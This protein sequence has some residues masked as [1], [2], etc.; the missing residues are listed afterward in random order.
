MDGPVL[1]M[2]RFAQIACALSLSTAAAAQTPPP[3]KPTPDVQTLIN[4]AFAAQ[5]KGDFAEAMKIAQQAIALARD[6]K[7]RCGEGVALRRLGAAQGYLGHTDEGLATTQQA[8]AIAVEIGDDLDQ[9]L[10]LN[11]LA[12]TNNDLGNHEKALIYLNQALPLARASGSLNTEGMVLGNIGASAIDSNPEQS[13]TSYQQG[14]T[15]FGKLGSLPG[16]VISYR[17]L[18]VAHTHLGQPA[19]AVEAYRS[20]IAL[21][22]AIGNKRD[23]SND[24]NAIADIYQAIGKPREA[25]AYELQALDLSRAIG[26]KDG[27][28]MALIGIGIIFARM[29]E[30]DSAIDYFKQGETLDHATGRRLSEAN[31]IADQGAIYRMKGDFATAQRL[32]EESLVMAKELGDKKNLNQTEIMLG[33]TFNDEGKPQQALNCL[34]SALLYFRST[35][36]HRDE[37]GTLNE[38]GR[39]YRLENRASEAEASYLQALPIARTDGFRELEAVLLRNLARVEEKLGRP[40]DASS[41]FRSA[42]AIREGIRGGFGSLT[43]AKQSYLAVNRNV[44]TD[45]LN[46][47]LRQGDASTA[48]AQAQKMKARS[49]LDLL[50]S[51]QV[52]I[53]S[54]LTPDE[55]AKEQELRDEA[56][57]LNVAMV[58]QGV[59]NAVGS[60]KRYEALRDKLKAVEAKL[61]ALTNALYAAHPDLAE[62]R[63]ATTA[64]IPDLAKRLPSDTALLDYVVASDKDVRFFV[65]T[66]KGPKANLK[67]YWAPGAYK[68]RS[69]EASALHAACSNPNK[70]YLQLSKSLYNALIQPAM[71]QLRGKKRLVIC[72]DGALWDV[73]FAALTDR[74]GASLASKFEI[75]YAYSATG[76]EASLARA[77]RHL[78]SIERSMLVV[79]NPDFGSAARFGAL[80]EIPGQRPIEPASRPIEPASRP[81][82]PGSRPIEPASRLSHLATRALDT[83]SLGATRGTAI[84]ALPGTQAEA[85]ALKKLFPDATVLTG[86]QAQE[87]TFKSEAG[88]YRYLHLATHGFVNDGSPLLSSVILANPKRGSH[89][90]GFLTAREIYGMH[91]NADMTVLSACNTARGENRTGEGV[92]GLTW[93]LFVAG[94]PTQVVSQWAVDD[95]STAKLMSRFYQNLKTRKMGK[96]QALKEAQAWLRGSNA[97]YAHPYYWAPFVL[98]GAWN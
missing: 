64:T 76:M 18:A 58:H 52:Q 79:A 59:E 4:K 24:S 73:P 63:V 19:Q 39:S 16:Q 88:N 41:D 40:A 48:F 67:V 75:A 22:A 20:A 66:T 17:G 43:E 14:V 12:A 42:I 86:L 7:D 50:D 34:Q 29:D 71:A 61:V 38:I 51:N 32:I 15:I 94:S 33:E 28:A 91:L 10:A 54:S 62:E 80:S 44:Y 81:I 30:Y 3:P 92:V 78:G 55:R 95:A 98:N 90:D 53:G 46:L 70:P 65:V 23:Q 49:L 2:I 45:Y 1:N 11:N 9:A 25:L 47:L 69:A 56:D 31:A 8:L 96:A 77:S 83:V 93:A 21:D 97:K 37:C 85:D 57:S 6:R 68:T 89:E 35:Q 72:P 74:K 60:K 36:N 13:V 5:N 26:F 84:P 27:Q 82:E 87:S